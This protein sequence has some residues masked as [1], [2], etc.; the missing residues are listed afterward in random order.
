MKP[1][2]LYCVAIL[3]LAGMLAACAG[4]QGSLGPSGP[5]GPA[6]PEGPQGPT[7]PAGPAGPKGP[8]T[9]AAA[10]YIGDST[11]S[12]CHKDTYDT[13]MRSGHPW[14]LTK[15]E[16]GKAPSFPF[17]KIDKLPEGYTWDDISYV[18]GGYNLKARFLDN[19]GNIITAGPG[20]TAADN[21]YL[22][23]WVSGNILLGINTGLVSFHAGELG[24]Q[25]A[26]GE[27]HSTGFS[28]GG[29]QDDL[30]G[31]SG[32]WNQPG[33]RCEACHGPGS[34]HA[35]S[36]QG[37]LMRIERDAEACTGCH[38][39]GADVSLDVRDGFIQ[40]HDQYGDLFQS[41]HMILDCVTCHDPHTGVVQL[42]KDGLPTTS[43]QCQDCHYE[44]AKTQ[45]NER[46]AV[47]RMA[48]TECHM[49]RLIQSATGDA[50]KFTGDIRTHVVAID[51]TQI[52]QMSEDGQTM[53]THIGLDFACRHCHGAGIGAPKTDEELLAAAAG[54]H[55]PVS[56]P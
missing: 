18:I 15:V 8:V 21:T 45:N 6:G 25:Y 27:C 1:K 50:A 35:S 23:Q 26:C 37:F 41:K 48:C 36:P 49:P 14:Q 10:E 40:H 12:G 44:E 52:G 2:F 46:H 31:I 19:Q 47:M 5:A 39:R 38:M 13:Y 55:T 22:N 3:L 51:A 4:P 24:M 9:E 30:P 56:T 11:C 29:N 54:Y 28:S 42:R 34:L 7:G 17:T 20:A 16:E 43:V 33:V 32:T 53:L